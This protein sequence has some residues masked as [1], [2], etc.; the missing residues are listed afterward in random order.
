VDG[1][2]SEDQTLHLHDPRYRATAR[3]SELNAGLATRQVVPDPEVVHD[4]VVPAPASTGH[5]THR[6]H[7]PGI[8][9]LVTLTDNIG[10]TP[11]VINGKIAKSMN[12]YYN[13]RRRGDV[14]RR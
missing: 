5:A 13:K 14:V 2:G 1:Y 3:G 10:D 9:H 7:R 4:H 11:I 8:E 6:Q 12:H